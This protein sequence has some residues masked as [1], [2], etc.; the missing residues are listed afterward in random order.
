[1]G[2]AS[3]GPALKF[4]RKTLTLTGAAGAGQSASPISLF[5][6][7][8]MVSVALIVGRC[9]SSLVSAGGGTIA[10]GVTGAT[11]LFIGATT[12]TA[13][14]TSAM[15]WA[16]TT[17]NAQGIAAPAALK[18]IVIAANVIG[19][20]AVADITAGVI[21]FDVYYLPLSAGAGLVAA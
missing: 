3:P 14:T 12:G 19:T 17:P 1:M 20:V 18:D 11:T 2:Y 10:L 16:S 6:I 21:E 5:T 4:A 9:T 15:I 7:T 13:I 8:G